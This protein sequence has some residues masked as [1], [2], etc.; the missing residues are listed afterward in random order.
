M[1]LSSLSFSGALLLMHRPGITLGTPTNVYSIGKSDDELFNGAYEF[2]AFGMTQLTD[3]PQNWTLNKWRTVTTLSVENLDV[4]SAQVEICETSFL[5]TTYPNINVILGDSSS[6]DYTPIL[7]NTNNNTP[8]IDEDFVDNDNDNVPNSQDCDPNDSSDGILVINDNPLAA[9]L[10]ENNNEIQ[11]TAIVNNNVTATFRARTVTLFPGFKANS[12]QFIAIAEGVCKDLKTS[13]TGIDASCFGESDGSATITGIDGDGNYSYLW[14]TG[15]T[16]AT[17]VNLPV[18]TYTA[19][20]T[21]GLGMIDSASITIGYDL[22]DTDNDLITDGCDCDPNDTSDGVTVVSNK[23]IW[24]ST[25]TAPNKLITTG[26]IKIDTVTVFK[27]TRN[28][29]FLPGFKAE[30]GSN[31][32]ATIEDVCVPPPMPF[33]ED[34]HNTIKEVQAEFLDSKEKTSDLKKEPEVVFV[35]NPTSDYFQIRSELSVKSYGVYD[36][37]G[38]ELLRGIGQEVNISHLP[39]GTYIVRVFFDEKIVVG[40]IVKG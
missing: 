14:N 29:I 10:Y 4:N 28:I 38:K 19:T 40:L 22:T 37:L 31:L 7:S 27:A 11:S 13:I 15:S 39:S 17:L 6:T 20:V 8:T 23:P 24:D 9:G 34:D 33:W 12:S 18:G 25:Y 32:I 30:P 16:N 21:D 26:T 36:L 35:P 3:F 1:I 5:N 2:Q